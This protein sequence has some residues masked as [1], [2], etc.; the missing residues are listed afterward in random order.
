VFEAYPSTTVP[1]FL[2]AEYLGF[3]PPDHCHICGALIADAYFRVQQRMACR[4][5]AAKAGFVEKG[6][7]SS[8]SRHALAYLAAAVFLGLAASVF[9][10]V[11]SGWP[12][13]VLSFGIGYLV[14]QAVKKSASTVGEA[15]L[16]MLAAVLTYLA[17]AP[18]CA[19]A[20]QTGQMMKSLA[21]INWAERIGAWSVLALVSPIVEFVQT[22]NGLFTLLTV[23]VGMI[24]AAKQV[25]V[26]PPAVLGPFFQKA[27][28]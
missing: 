1:Q 5:C 18:G 14:G 27:K 17:V 25:S 7:A 2:T 16:A 8:T 11:V 22:D 3:V 19:F 23:L 6:Q 21:D 12:I 15:R 24:I 26:E 9:L 10:A 13:P 28:E 20:G 4:S